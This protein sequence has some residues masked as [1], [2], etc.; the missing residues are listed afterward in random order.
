MSTFATIAVAV[1]VALLVWWVS[2]VLILSLNSLGQR[3]YARSM[4]AATVVLAAA[5]CGIARVR[6]EPTVSG[7]YAGFACAV[8]VW[9]WLEMSFL[10]GY[11]V[12]SRRHA[13]PAHC[14]GFGHFVHAIQ[15]II[16]HELSIIVLAAAVFALGWSGPNRVAVWTIAILWLMRE[17]TKLNLF[18]GVRNLSDD[19]L[20]PHLAYLPGF[21]RK[22][23]MNFLFPVSVTVAV[24]ALTLQVQRMLA[25]GASEFQVAGYALLAT[26]TALGILE[27]WVLVLPFSPSALWS[28]SV[29]SREAAG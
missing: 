22:R 8:A 18:L 11:L 7:A 9:G 17:S 2:T 1:P 3:T 5:L 26:M 6:D 16:W 15:A 4:A 23:P 19:L 24:V 21:F 14:G 25:P 12:G 10:L 13:C 29:R 28:W 20:P 27:H